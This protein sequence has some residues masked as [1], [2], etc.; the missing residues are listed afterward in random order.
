MIYHN[1]YKVFHLIEIQQQTSK[2][3]LFDH[4]VHEI[5]VKVISTSHMDV[6]K[7]LLKRPM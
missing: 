4:H 3:R 5:D 2:T 7:T 1:T 6:K